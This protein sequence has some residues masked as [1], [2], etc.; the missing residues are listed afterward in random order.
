MLLKNNVERGGSG[1]LTAARAASALVTAMLIAA[2]LLVP[3][4]AHA[5]TVLSIHLTR[6]LLVE[7]DAE[8]PWPIQVGPVEALPRQSYLRI[9]GLPPGALLSEGHSIGSGTWAVPLTALPRLKLKAPIVDAGRYEVRVVLHAIDGSQLAESAM[10]L[11]LAQPIAPAPPPAGGT[12]IMALTAP[13]APAAEPR[14]AASAPAV[15]PAP[16]AAPK[17]SS[18]QERTL[19]RHM[20][21]GDQT[22]AE[23][24]IAAARLLYQRAADQGLAAA[25]MALAATYD[26]SEL[27]RLGVRGLSADPAT[28]K[29]WYERARELGAADAEARLRRLAGAR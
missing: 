20:Q 26:P 25:A 5:Q 2:A 8:T 19:Q 24:D 10:W 15:A 16:T 23:G 11:V 28:A 18:E 17:L 22:L 29:R 7:T 9:R 13:Q 27:A 21:K 12:R 1:S 3:P 6:T 4:T 14:V